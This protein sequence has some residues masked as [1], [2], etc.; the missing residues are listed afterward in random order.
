MF[1]ISDSTFFCQSHFITFFFF[2]PKMQ[3]ISFSYWFFFFLI[4]KHW[5]LFYAIFFKKPNTKRYR[6]TEWQHQGFHTRS[7]AGDL[8]SYIIHTIIL[9]SIFILLHQSIISYNHLAI[10]HIQDLFLNICL[11]WNFDKKIQKCKC[12]YTF[13]SYFHV[14]LSGESG[15]CIPRTLTIYNHYI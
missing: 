10:T 2:S 9:P 13:L 6:Y 5:L 7:S 1:E 12:C 3:L 15:K 8:H 11:I 4:N 14:I